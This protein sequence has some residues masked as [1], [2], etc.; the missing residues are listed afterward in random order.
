MADFED[1]ENMLNTSEN[2]INSVGIVRDSDDARRNTVSIVGNPQKGGLNQTMKVHNKIAQNLA[3]DS[4]EEIDENNDAEP[5]ELV[6]RDPDD[7]NKTLDD[8]F[9]LQIYGKRDPKEKYIP[10]ESKNAKFFDRILHPMQYGSLRGSIFGLSSM[11]LE[12]GSMVLA[13]YHSFYYNIFNLFPNFFKIF[14]FSF[15]F[16]I[17]TIF[18]K[19]P[20]TRI[21]TLFIFFFDFFHFSNFFIIL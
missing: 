14:F 19:R 6:A 21:I 10:F 8:I 3:E 9:T 16:K 1:T 4:Q 17:I 2:K 20:F 7:M 13:F 15:F 12:A 11:C 5:E 18:N